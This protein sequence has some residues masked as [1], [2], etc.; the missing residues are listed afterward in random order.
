MSDNKENNSPTQEVGK[1][2]EELQKMLQSKYMEYQMIEQQM[3]QAQQQV[4]KVDSQLGE[5]QIIIK[6]LKDL[7]ES[8]KDDEILVPISSGIFVKGK[9]E[10]PNDFLVNVGSG[11]IVNK[12][13]EETVSLLEEQLVELEKF[14]IEAMNQVQQMAINSQNL[15]QELKLMI[16][17]S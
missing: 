10:N 6:G 14:R 2:Q 11:I 8:S 15:E 9:I 12:N 16:E 4:Q 3:K 1:S 7:Q 5:I 17:D 13:F